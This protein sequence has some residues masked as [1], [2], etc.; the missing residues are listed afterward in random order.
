[1]K[2]R[3]KLTLK[4]YMLITSLSVLAVK[5]FKALTEAL[6]ENYSNVREIGEKIRRMFNFVSLKSSIK[7]C[8]HDLKLLY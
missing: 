7:L 2:I 5:N 1:M 4:K 8:F 6:L 3:I